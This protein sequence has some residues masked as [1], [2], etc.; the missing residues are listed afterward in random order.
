ML[1]DAETDDKVTVTGTVRYRWKDPW[2]QQ[3][4][5]QRPRHRPTT[6]ANGSVTREQRPHSGTRT[7]SSTNGTRASGHHTQHCDYTLLTDVGPRRPPQPQ[8]ETE[9]EEGTRVR[10]RT[11]R[12]RGPFW[13]ER[14]RCTEALF[15]WQRLSAEDSVGGMRR[16]ATCREGMFAKGLFDKRLLCT[17]NLKSTIWKQAS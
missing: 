9:P 10:T 16:Q 4:M 12:V 3:R 7:V 14:R 8:C 11:A 5:G 13:A 2:T 6:T 1:P 17:K 15:N